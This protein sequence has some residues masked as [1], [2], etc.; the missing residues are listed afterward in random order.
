MFKVVLLE[1]ESTHV[2]LIKKLLHQID[3]PIDLQVFRDSKSFVS[4]FSEINPDLLISDY[5][6]DEMNGLDALY[7]AHDTYPELPVILMSGLMDEDNLLETM[8]KGASDVVSKDNL[9]RLIPAINR[10]L[11]NYR[12]SKQRERKLKETKERY[13]ALVH[14]IK[15]LVWEANTEPFSFNYISPKIEEIFGFKSD[16]F[17]DDPDSFF[18]LIHE[19]D[20]NR[21]K[22]FYLNFDSSS[23]YGEVEYRITN[24]YNDIIWIRETLSNHKLHDGQPVI[25]GMMID[26]TESKAKELLLQKNN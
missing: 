18:Q 2:E 15:G 26:I 23:K 19:E 10:E 11:E 14:S 16:T 21:V 4:G 22:H 8:N 9:R 6:I 25:R 7:H 1:D 20:K 17:Y 5:F 13:R 24:K 12:L 3:A